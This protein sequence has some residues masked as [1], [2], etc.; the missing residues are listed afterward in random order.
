MVKLPETLA[1][2]LA[3][4]NLGVTVAF[5]QKR[6]TP[7]LAGPRIMIGVEAIRY[8]PAGL[9]NA[10]FRN[11]DGVT[12]RG[13]RVSGTLF[14]ESYSSYP[15]SAR[16]DATLLPLVLNAVLGELGD[17]TVGAIWLDPPYYDAGTD[18]FRHRLRIELSAYCYQ[19]A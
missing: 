16:Q 3:E 5:P 11:A 15:K 1:A 6:F 17:Y 8:E 4:K 10:L 9:D 7:N 2:A 19:T 14:L 13:R 12:Q 18:C